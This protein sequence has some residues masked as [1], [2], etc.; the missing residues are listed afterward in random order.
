MPVHVKISSAFRRVT[1]GQ[2]ELII[3]ASNIRQL[4]GLIDGQCPGF[5]K[6]V[7]DEDKINSFVN[8]F[9]DGT[10]IDTLQGFDT[11]LKNHTEV[12]FIAALSGG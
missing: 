7:L 6:L 10:N 8:I 3:N 1:K 2:S 5:Q 12:M 9:V 11:A 4:I